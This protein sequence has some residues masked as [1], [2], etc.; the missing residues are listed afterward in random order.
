[1]PMPYFDPNDPYALGLGSMPPQ[2]MEQ[3]GFDPSL[4]GMVPGAGSQA[5]GTGEPDYSEIGLPNDFWSRMAMGSGAH[6]FNIQQH[7]PLTGAGAIAAF[8]A[9]FG[10]QK[11]GAAARNI[12]EVER[13]NAEVRAAAQRMAQHKHEIRKLEI[14]RGEIAD[15]AKQNAGERESLARSQRVPVKLPDGSTI[16]VAPGDY[17]GA[18]PYAATTGLT[19]PGGTGMTGRNKPPGAGGLGG[20]YG[21]F[22]PKIVAKMI[23]DGQAPPDSRGFSRGQWGLVAQEIGKLDPNYSITKSQLDWGGA[24]QYTKTLNQGQQVMLRQRSQ[25]AMVTADYITELIR[26]IRSAAPPRTPVTVINRVQLDAVKNGLWGPGAAD[27]ATKLSAQ[28]AAWRLEMAAVYAGGYAPQEQH[29]K[30]ASNLI[31]DHWALN[32]IESGLIIGRRDTNIRLNAVGQTGA[33]TPSNPM[34]PGVTP[35]QI[36]IGPNA[37]PLGAPADTTGGSALMISPSGKQY[38]VPLS[39]IGEATRNGYALVKQ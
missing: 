4:G 28:I 14:N 22:E 15:L 3:G 20:A 10:N 8:L 18:V 2:V 24:S 9:G 5:P 25:N 31:G 23:V 30:E 1:M 17:T 19:G 11:A 13:K 34:M 7:G 35:T 32:R 16:Y 33:V 29:L 12:S 26:D 6:P 39:G 36:N 38:R 27:A 21:T 37:V